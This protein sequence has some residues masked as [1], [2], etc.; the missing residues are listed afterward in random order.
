[1]DSS[2]PLV[3]VVIDSL[4]QARYLEAALLS[5][6]SQDYPNLELIVGDGG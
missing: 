5:V 3:T 6:F 1:M 2:L 4:N